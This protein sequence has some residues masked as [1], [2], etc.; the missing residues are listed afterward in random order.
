VNKFKMPFLISVDEAARRFARAI[1]QKQSFTVIPWTMGIAAR[2]LRLVPNWLYDR[3]FQFMPR[4]P[5]G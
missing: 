2:V 3:L 1:A 5:R 4:K